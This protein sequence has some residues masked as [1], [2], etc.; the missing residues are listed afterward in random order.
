[1]YD[2]DAL[3]SPRRRGVIASLAV[4]RRATHANHSPASGEYAV[5]FVDL[6]AQ[7]REIEDDIRAAIERVLQHGQFLMG[8][9][10]H[11]L[12]R[13]LAEYCGVEHAIAT[14]SGTDALLI[15][16][17]AYQV[18]PGDAVIAPPFTFV[19]TAEVIQLLGATTVF[20]DVEEH[21]FNIDPVRL[22]ETVKRIRRHGKYHLKGI[23]PVDLFGLPADYDA[24][25]PIARENGLFVL[26]DAAQS[27]GGAIGGKK[28]GAFGDL[29]ATSFFPAKPL[30]CYGDGGAVFTGNAELAELVRSIRMHG[31]G[32]DRYE[33]VRTGITGRLDTIQAAILSC[34][35]TVFEREL[36]ARQRLADIYTRE[37]EGVVKTPQIPP[38]HR[39]AWAQYTLRST[40]RDAI[41]AH[42]HAEDIP[43]A[44]YYPCPLHR[45]PAFSKA[46]GAGVSMPVSEMLSRQVLSLPIH[47]YLG[48][49]EQM[50]IIKE[51]KAAV[52][53]QQQQ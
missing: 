19:A 18:G 26:A 8:P 22:A 38:G 51:V 12:E 1:M 23:I 14:A 45:Q 36:A 30:G 43:T 13:E 6:N 34:K 5:K 42:L 7:F 39:S 4:V 16:L 37:L 15:A 24:I 31:M 40:E 47:P 2:G 35:L 11:T 53:G 29:S 50:K 27:F 44:V 52:S 9:E 33:H 25:E 32:T 46:D 3:A 48:E 21:G 41:R 20:V 10:V 17:M 49:A 28:A